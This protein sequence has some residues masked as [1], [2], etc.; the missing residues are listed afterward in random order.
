MFWWERN[1]LRLI[2][3]NLREVD[4]A[5][6]VDQLISDL[7]E[8]SAN[9]LMMNA[10]GIFAFYPTK[11]RYQYQTPYL[12]QDVLK[13]VIDKTHQA[14]M[15]FIARFDF[16][17]AHESIFKEKPEWFYR[18]KDGHEVNYNGIVHT[19]INGY[20]QQTYSLKMIEEVI[21]KYKVDGIFFNMFG[22][23]T[24][25]YS[26]NDYGI[27]HCLSC[28]TRFKEMY[29]LELPPSNDRSSERYKKYKEFQWRT[30][31]EML[32]R[33]H[34]FVKK[35]NPHIAISTY[36]DH[37]VDIVRNES[38]T[39][40]TRPHPVWLYSSSENVKAIEDTWE[41]K[42]ISNCCI[43]AVD[44][45]YRFMG[46]SKE[47]V[48]IRL[49]ESIASGSGLDFCIIGVFDGYS[50]HRN[51]PIVKE[52]FRFHEENE[53]YFGQ[54]ASV[55]EIALI[56]PT[57]PRVMNNKEYFGIFKMLKEQHKPFDVIC[58]HELNSNEAKLESFQ[59]IVIP[60][61]REWEDDQLDVLSRIHKQGVR[62]VAT[63]QTFTD[64]N[65]AEILQSLF[66]ATFIKS[67]TENDA[68]YLLSQGKQGMEESWVYIDGAFSMIN[69]SESVDQWF[70][71]LSP[72]TFGPPERA[73]N[74]KLSDFHGV[75]LHQSEYG[76]NAFI[77][78]QPG[79]LY[80][81][82]GYE[83]H[84]QLFLHVLNHIEPRSILKTDAASSVEVFINRTANEKYLVQVLNLSGFNGVTY[85]EPIAMERIQIQLN[86][87]KAPKKI[88]QLN[89]K[90]EILF[91]TASDDTILTFHVEQLH[92]YA[93][94][95][96]ETNNQ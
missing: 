60:D 4:A 13:E 55:E 51:F 7:K 94:Y 9:T 42:L 58:Q 84:K 10:G 21:T 40:L 8:F 2:Q 89:H 74:H 28:Q 35:I 67:T 49:Y 85:T 76:L 16:S 68:S 59:L 92:R 46:V 22:Y 12:K 17:K 24:S 88:T 27:C 47:E 96:I 75:G 80:Y 44:L 19:C 90:K 26:S 86:L 77:T 18:T 65:R 48:S 25:D 64:T 61:I 31:K 79:T 6:N 20:Y 5:L 54:L 33:I 37:K 29:Q 50:D 63:G 53:D 73:Y 36:N 78:W 3:T 23:Q 1:N 95:V 87:D 52:I 34:D 30:T 43:N 41:D 14:G 83:E 81:Q 39:K 11:L 56:K 66:D 91:E 71:F 32:D 57:G 82:H 45:Q 62:I 38:N 70:P 93:A 15:K 69:F 72:S